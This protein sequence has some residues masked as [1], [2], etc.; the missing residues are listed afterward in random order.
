[1]ELQLRLMAGNAKGIDG[2]QEIMEETSTCA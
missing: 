1:M 2:A